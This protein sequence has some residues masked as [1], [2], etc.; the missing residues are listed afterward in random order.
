MFFHFLQDGLTESNLES[1]K[2]SFVVLDCCLR[3]RC[4]LEKGNLSLIISLTVGITGIL[5]RVLAVSSLGVPDCRA[6]ICS[7]LTTGGIRM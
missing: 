2:P 4:L 5:V 1:G 3:C 6:L 7:E